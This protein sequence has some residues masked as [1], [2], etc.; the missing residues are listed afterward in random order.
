MQGCTGCQA[1]TCVLSFLP[2]LQVRLVLAPGGWYINTT[3]A[4]FGST[5]YLTRDMWCCLD[6]FYT[7]TT[8]GKCSGGAF[9]PY[10]PWGTAQNCHVR[11]AVCYGGRR[12]VHAC[13]RG[14]EHFAPPFPCAQP[15][16]TAQYGS[17][18]IDLRSTQLYVTQA[19][20]VSLQYIPISNVP[21]NTFQPNLGGTIAPSTATGQ[22][23]TMSSVRGHCGSAQVGNGQLAVR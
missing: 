19:N 5:A 14:A 1:G 21:A 8:T 9:L 11:T 23:I 12:P 18:S 16:R 10:V 22:L 7:S 15:D 20:Q 3:D 6:D 2:P 4:T 13:G 17:A